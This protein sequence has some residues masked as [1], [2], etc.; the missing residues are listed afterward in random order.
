LLEINST[1][2]LKA[3]GPDAA[4]D[5]YDLFDLRETPSASRAVERPP[6]PCARAVVEMAD[7][8]LCASIAA[9][10]LSDAVEILGEV[11]RRRLP[12][13]VP[14]LAALIRRFKG[15]E[16]RGRIIEQTQA[17]AALVAVGGFEAAAVVKSAIE[18]GEFNRANLGTALAAA[19]RLGVR[20][21][22]RVVEAAL[23]HDDAEIRLAACAFASARPNL[24]ARLME[25]LG[26]QDKRVAIAAACALGDFGRVEAR[27]ILTALLKTSPS[28]AVIAAAANVADAALLVQLGKLARERDR[29]HDAVVEALEDCESQLAATIRRDLVCTTTGLTPPQTDQ[30]GVPNPDRAAACARAETAEMSG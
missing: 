16:T 9:V 25:R 26:D 27:P 12:S 24:I 13:A 15:F 3:S 21:E 28:V 14:Q 4:T 5:Q 20:L 29:F 30:R 1:A 6:K 23:V 11:A 19:T 10:D 7:D 22:P 2:W 18:R 17:L 8:D